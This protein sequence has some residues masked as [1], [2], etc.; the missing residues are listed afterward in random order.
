MNVNTRNFQEN[1]SQLKENNINSVRQETIE[2]V[3]K[4]TDIWLNLFKLN[5]PKIFKTVWW[6]EIQKHYVLADEI[7]KSKDV[8]MDEIKGLISDKNVDSNIRMEIVRALSDSWVKISEELLNSL[9]SNLIHVT[10]WE[11]NVVNVYS[12]TYIYK[13]LLFRNWYLYKGTV[14]SIEEDEDNKWDFIYNLNYRSV[15]SSWKTIK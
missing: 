9:E 1:N 11:D 15:R 6:L 8:S 13:I 7:V 10:K 5:H 4:S 12:Q 3:Y 2:E 14:K